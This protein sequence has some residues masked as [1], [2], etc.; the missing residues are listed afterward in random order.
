VVQGIAA[1]GDSAIVFRITAKAKA[2]QQ[3]TVEMRLRRRI[4]EAFQRESIEIP[5]PRCTVTM[6][7]GEPKIN[8]EA[9]HDRL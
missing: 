5:Y 3:W 2:L 8:L 9:N 7:N 4:K 1:F 6:L